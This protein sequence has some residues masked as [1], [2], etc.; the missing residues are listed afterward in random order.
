MASSG[1]SAATDATYYQIL[2]KLGVIRAPTY[3]ERWDQWKATHRI[4]VRPGDK[5][6]RSHPETLR[7]ADI[8]ARVPFLASASSDLDDGYVDG[9]TDDAEGG[10]LTRQARPSPRKELAKDDRSRSL[11]GYTPNQSIDYDVTTLNPP[12]R[13]STPVYAQEQGYGRSTPPLPPYSVS[14]VGR[15]LDEPPHQSVEGMHTP[16][17]SQPWLASKQEMQDAVLRELERRADNFYQTGLIGRCWDVWYRSSDWIQVSG[18]NG[19]DNAS[20][21][22]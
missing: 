15:S 13:T 21:I 10:S 18:A 3:G 14:E 4:A 20:D 2:L 9:E 22:R 12:I 5:P 7:T 16:R 8:R 6:R 19:G 1:L 17:A 11:V